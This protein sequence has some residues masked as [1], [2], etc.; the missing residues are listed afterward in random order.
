MKK[1]PRLPTDQKKESTINYEIDK[2]VQYTQQST[3]N[4]KRLT[5]AVVVNYRK[6][7]GENGEITH[8]PLT[9]NEIKEIN[10]LVKEAMGYSEKRGDSLTVTNSLFTAESETI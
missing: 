6:K 3:G 7:I 2:T 1:T 4:I 10:G 5:A 9:A 8:D